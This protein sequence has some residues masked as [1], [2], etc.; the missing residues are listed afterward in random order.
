FKIALND[1]VASLTVGLLNRVLDRLDGG[2]ARHDAA[3]GEKASLH[4]SVDA[5]AHAGLPGDLVG[6]D[7]V[8]AQVFVDKV[9]LCRP[10]QVIPDRFRTKSAV[11]QEHGAWLGL[12]QDIVT[13]QEVELMA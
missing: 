4:N 6:V 13:L 12:G 9:G 8:E 1:R 2:L 11:E 7:D 3:D 10:R 5:A